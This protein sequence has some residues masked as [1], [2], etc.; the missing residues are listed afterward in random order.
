M[1]HT[2]AAVSDDALVRAQALECPTANSTENGEF[3]NEAFWERHAQLLRKAWRAYPPLDHKLYTMNA[4]FERNFLNPTFLQAATSLRNGST[5]DE[6]TIKGFFDNSLPGVW[7]TDQLFSPSFLQSM[8]AELE[9]LETAKIPVRR[10]N[11]MNRHG[12]ILEHVDGGTSGL[13]DAFHDLITRY[14]R[15]VAETLFPESVG[16][17]D[18][19]DHFAFTIRYRLDEDTRLKEHRDAS[20]VTMNLC[21]GREGYQGGRLYFVEPETGERQYLRFKPGTAVFHRGSLRH[22]AEPITSGERT[23]LVIWLF[24][25]GGYVRDAP[26]P[27]GQRMDLRQRW[28]PD[29]ASS[30]RLMRDFTHSPADREEL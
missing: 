15:P 11:G 20:C 24:G 17:G 18:A 19:S 14:V 9:H 30:A 25:E 8:L 7:Q 6:Q 21:L 27:E 12:A 29:R 26:Y 16:P 1:I 10:P 3:E 2:T 28:Q 13:A 4:N 23:N 22:S 5:S